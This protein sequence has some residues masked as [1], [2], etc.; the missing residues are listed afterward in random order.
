MTELIKG[1][2]RKQYNAKYYKKNK[3]KIVRYKKHYYIKKK[4]KIACQKA[5]EPQAIC[6]KIEKNFA[7]KQYTHDSRPLLP[8]NKNISHS[9]YFAVAVFPNI[10]YKQYRRLP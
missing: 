8:A 6:S 10:Y 5:N 4:E 3:D 7:K 1:K 2:T 9:A